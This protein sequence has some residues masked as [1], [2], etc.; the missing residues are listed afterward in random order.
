MIWI[1]ILQ[2]LVMFLCLNWVFTQKKLLREKAKEST[3]N[4]QN[5]QVQEIKTYRKNQEEKQDTNNM[6]KLLLL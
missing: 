5:A 4:L 1:R 2:Y 3:K 6:F